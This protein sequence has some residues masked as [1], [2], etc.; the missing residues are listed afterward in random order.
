MFTANKNLNGSEVYHIPKILYH[1]RSHSGST[2]KS[3]QEKGSVVKDSSLKTLEDFISSTGL[4]AKLET[5]DEIHWNINRQ[6]PLNPPS[7][8]L[9]LLNE[10]S[11]DLNDWYVT[12]LL[13]FTD[14]PGK[15]DVVILNRS[16]CHIKGFKENLRTI[17]SFN[18]DAEHE[19]LCICSTRAT[20]IHSFW[21]SEL[22]AQALDYDI[23]F[24]GP[25]FVN[26]AQQSIVSA[27]LIVD[28]DNILKS[29]YESSPW[30]FS[31]DKYR[32]RLKQNFT[33]MHPACIVGRE[34]LF[35]LILNPFSLASIMES[36]LSLHLRGLHNLWIPSVEMDINDYPSINFDIAN[37]Q[38]I[39][40]WFQQAGY[41]PSFNPNLILRD[42][43]PNFED[44]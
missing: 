19:F 9:V 31:G 27:G 23:G 41:D 16:N 44:L 40:S 39:I 29:I 3:V 33:F 7:L 28:N 18:R 42:G 13:K 20:P 36:C 17:G 34:D 32:A 30:S 21:L 5:V 38:K 6:L 12:K 24:C 22:V 10:G 8:L 25:K 2:A 26:V 11:N 43:I 15:I 1:W 4:H 37:S 14:Y 35:D